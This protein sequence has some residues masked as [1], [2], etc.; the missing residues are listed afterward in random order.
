[1]ASGSRVEDAQSVQAP[2]AAG[3]AAGQS[4]RI[5]DQ[6]LPDIR[7]PVEI[8]IRGRNATSVRPRN[9]G[10]IRVRHETATREVHETWRQTTACAC[11]RGSGLAAVGIQSIRQ[12]RGG[13]AQSAFCNFASSS[14]PAVLSIA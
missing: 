5:V 13:A 2:R 8:P 7:P 4:E 1:M 11:R 6:L 12:Q 14:V 10:D 9:R 3:L